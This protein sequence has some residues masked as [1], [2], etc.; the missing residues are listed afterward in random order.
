[1]MD[2]V[3]LKNCKENKETKINDQELFYYFVSMAKMYSEHSDQRINNWQKQGS[4]TL[5]AKLF[6]LQQLR[7]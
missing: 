3:R 7:T 6:C 4:R 5:T 2:H 1:M